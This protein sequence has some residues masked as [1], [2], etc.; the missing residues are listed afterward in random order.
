LIVSLALFARPAVGATPRAAIAAG[1]PPS[2]AE[3]VDRLARLCDGRHRAVTSL[4]VQ[5]NS[6]RDY[7]SRG[8]ALIRIERNFDRAQHSLGRPAEHR[9][10]DRAEAQYHRYRRLLPPLV[11]SSRRHQRRAWLV[12][13]RAHAYLI[14]A[15]DIIQVYGGRQ[16]CDLG[17]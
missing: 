15:S 1:K 3:F 13:Y 17:P 11:R 16:F 6:P 9:L 2:K 14:D 12:M 4:G 8:S 10:V 7:A 5:F